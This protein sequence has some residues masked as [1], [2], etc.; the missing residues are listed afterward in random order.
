VCL[1]FGTVLPVQHPAETNIIKLE[2]TL[3]TH[4][5]F[6]VADLR[7]PPL[8]ARTLRAD[9]YA[10]PGAVLGLERYHSELS[11]A[12]HAIFRLFHLDSFNIKQSIEHVILIKIIVNEYVLYIVIA[13][14]L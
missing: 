7:K 13:L 11:C 14:L 3:V 9:S 12:E 4:S 10:T 5:V 6:L 1:N 8:R 2:I